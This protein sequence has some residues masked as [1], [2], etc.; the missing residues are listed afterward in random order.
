MR[1]DRAI[2]AR[3]RDDFMAAVIATLLLIPQSLAYA[4]LAGMPAHLGLY[5]S[6]FPLLAYAAFGRSPVLAV[7]PVAL[8]SIMTLE[9][10]QG[11]A[12]PGSPEWIAAAILLAL[13]SGALLFL[14]G[15]LRLGF[16][17]Q[18][19]SHPVMSGFISGT[20]LLIVLSQLKALSGIPVEGKTALE[21]ITSLVVHVEQ[22]QATTLAVGIMSVLLMLLGRRFI[23]TWLGKTRLHSTT[24]DLIARAVPLVV[25]GLAT[26]GLIASGQATATPTVGSIPSGLPSLALPSLNLNG[27]QG[28]LISAVLIGLVGFI[29][30]VS[31]AQTVARRYKVAVDPDAELRGL[32]AANLASGL[33]GAFP[34]TGGLTRTVVN[35]DAGARSPVSSLFSAGLLL[36]VVLGAGDSLSHLPLAALAALIVVAVSTLFDIKGLVRAWQFDRMDGASWLITF[37]GVLSLGLEAGIIM[38][39]ALSAAGLLWRMSRPHIAV[40]GRIPCSEHFRNVQRH[41]VETLPHTIF[42]RIDGNLFFGNWARIREVIGARIEQHSGQIEH[43]VLNLASVNDIDTTALEGILGLQEDLQEDGV[44]LCLAEIRGPVGDKLK[45]HLHGIPVYL[46]SH[47]AY[48]ALMERPA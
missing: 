48:E 24:C 39:I 34:V 21:L 19:L 25:V 45:G 28:L 31:M 26:I 37:L 6:V 33:I 32:G 1:L 14:M 8:T 7:G 30:S 41:H 13:A 38:G 4:V 20:A 22:A 47:E 9:A 27:L 46:S 3:L 17:A 11:Y 15:L 36:L 5:A 2:D 18:L 40:L 42:L 35:M 12:V 43:L 29:E 23:R 44:S 16:L 10:L